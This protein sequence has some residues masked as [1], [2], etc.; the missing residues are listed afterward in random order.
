MERRKKRCLQTACLVFFILLLATL[1]LYPQYSKK[2]PATL[3]LPKNSV[4]PELHLPE[5]E[6]IK[7]WEKE[8]TIYFFIPSYVT[9][10]SLSLGTGLQWAEAEPSETEFQYDTVRNIVLSRNNETK[11][12]SKKICFKHSANLYTIYMDLKGTALDDI[13]REAFTETEI[14]VVSPDGS[15]NCQAVDGFVKGRGNSTWEREKKPY[16]LK[17][18]KDVNLCGIGPGK[19]WVLLANVY[20]ATKL[21]NKLLFDF[22]ADIGLHYSIDSEWADLYIN[23]EYRGNYLVC[24]KIDVNEQVVD[25]ANLEKEN[26]IIYESFTPF[27][28]ELFRGYET[29]QSP[30]N[31]SGGYIIEKDTTI[32]DSPCGFITEHGKNF[33]IVSPDNASLEEVFYI[34]D[35]FQNIED[36][37]IAHDDRLL[38]YIDAESFTRRYLIEELALNS[39]AYITSC[40]YYKERNDDKIYAGPV[41]DFDAVWGESDTID[42]KELG[43]VWQNY[44]ETTILSMDKYRST[45]AVLRY[46]QSFQAIPAYWDVLKD[47]YQDMQPQLESLLFEKIDAYASRVKQSV[48]LDSIR[49]NY[50]ENHAGN[51][52]SYD[53]NVRYIKFFLAQRINFLN[54]RFDMEEF[55]YTDTTETLHN[56]TCITEDSKVTFPIQDGFLL[57]KDALPE[58]DKEKYS[59][60][61]Y[62]WNHAAVSGYLPVYEDVTLYLQPLS[63]E[64]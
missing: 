24:E 8:D 58:Y 42:H 53:N 9:L 43:N 32:N 50:A 63:D 41:W 37:L 45:I 48:I 49:W 64:D 39:D 47:V 44:D 26:E 61:N 33:V 12:T 10:D 25:I 62:E 55:V 34:R 22:S 28:A 20:E 3:L 36:L 56:I 60:W 29:D 51:Y 54:K 14:M 31:I 30:A 7:G 15:I 19:K 5:G 40:Y 21:S 59:G 18:S 16:Y 35:C 27:K 52:T 4:L 57:K 13:T 6:I 2:V 46:E 1:Y 17:L 11:Q 23:G 38:Q